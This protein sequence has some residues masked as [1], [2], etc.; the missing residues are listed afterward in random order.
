M[1]VLQTPDRTLVELAA[2]SGSQ[3]QAPTFAVQAQAAIDRVGAKEALLQDPRT[4]IPGM[5]ATF[6][7]KLLQ[8]KVD[9]SQFTARPPAVPSAA[10]PVNQG[11]VDSVQEVLDKTPDLPLI[12][13]LKKSNHPDF[14]KLWVV[15]I[16]KEPLLPEAHFRNP[17]P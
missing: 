17:L 16:Y 7:Q 6:D 1:L 15:A 3:V 14:L 4:K 8:P 12:K 13:L 9:P 5:D 10:P 2:Q 11:F